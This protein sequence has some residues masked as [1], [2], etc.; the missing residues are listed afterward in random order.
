MSRFLSRANARSRFCCL[1][2]TR[3]CLPWPR[4]FSHFNHTI[5]AMCRYCVKTIK[6][7]ARTKSRI[8][9][10]LSG[11]RIVSTVY[12][13]M[14]YCYDVFLGH[15]SQ[16]LRRAVRALDGQQ[17]RKTT[18]L[19]KVS[20]CHFVFNVMFH[21]SYTDCAVGCAI[22]FHCERYQ[23]SPPCLCPSVDYYPA[24]EPLTISQKQLTKSRRGG[25]SRSFCLCCISK[26][27]TVRTLRL[28][29][30]AL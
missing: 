30:V 15:R 9:R 4:P 5:D 3:V 20:I 29:Q 1:N 19:K 16:W 11:S 10:I 12:M 22:M 27:Q 13:L 23:K 25:D 8:W 26:I 14:L 24:G 7:L 18:C 28:C 6:R 2:L 21:R 17:N